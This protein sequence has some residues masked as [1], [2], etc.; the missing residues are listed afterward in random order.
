MGETGKQELYILPNKYVQPTQICN[1][2][3]SFPYDLEKK[4]KID[5]P[6]PISNGS[7]LHF[8]DVNSDSY[9]DLLTII[10]AND[11]RK[12]MIFK[13]IPGQQGERTLE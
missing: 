9:P 1:T 3:D 12:A 8:G 11:F 2:Y 6:Y 4:R 7:V 13:N 5:L 10:T